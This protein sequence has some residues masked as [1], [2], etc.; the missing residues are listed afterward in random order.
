MTSS[1]LHYITIHGRPTDEV[2]TRDLGPI[3]YI[4]W[5]ELERARI[6]KKSPEWPV[7]IVRNP[8]TGEIALAHMRSSE[9]RK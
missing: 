1:I 5:L 6:L 3:D 7:K 8:S 4:L 2:V 9:I